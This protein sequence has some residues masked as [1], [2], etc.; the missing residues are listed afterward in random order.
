MHVPQ[1][2]KESMPKCKHRTTVYFFSSIGLG[3]VIWGVL[4]WGG[5]TYTWS[6]VVLAKS[7]L[8]KAKSQELF[9]QKPRGV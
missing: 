8:Q 1:H 2:D 4:I 6:R 5:G 9:G 3:V 7:C